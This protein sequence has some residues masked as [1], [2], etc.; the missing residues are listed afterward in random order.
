M[1]PQFLGLIYKPT[2]EI[3][4]FGGRHI[5]LWGLLK[6]VR[7][8]PPPAKGGRFVMYQIFQRLSKNAPNRR[9]PRSPQRS[10]FPITNRMMHR[11]GAEPAASPSVRQAAFV[12][13]PSLEPARSSGFDQRPN[14][15]KRRFKPNKRSKTDFAIAS[16]GTGRGTAPRSDFSRRGRERRGAY[17]RLPF[18]LR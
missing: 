14:C 15:G 17:V 10:R 3:G 7:H 12:I 2:V 5:K 13:F 16:G 8:M 11:R 6:E 1:P 9:P 18:D 4:F